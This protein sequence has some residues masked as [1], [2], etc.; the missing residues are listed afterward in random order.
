MVLIGGMGQYKLSHVQLDDDMGYD[1]LSPQLS[2]FTWIDYNVF[3]NCG[4]CP[5]E[6]SEY[7]LASPFSLE[8]QIIVVSKDVMSPSSFIIGGH[9]Y[10]LI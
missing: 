6:I 10:P 1:T 8:S 4:L 7:H 3:A 2:L 5:F 9:S